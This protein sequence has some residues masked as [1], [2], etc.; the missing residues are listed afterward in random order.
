MHP[1]LCACTYWLL[2]RWGQWQGRLILT[3]HLVLCQFTNSSA[4]RTNK[5]VASKI[6][7]LL[8]QCSLST[9]TPPKQILLFCCLYEVS[10]LNA[11]FHCICKCCTPNLF[12]TMLHSILYL[13][14]VTG[15]VLF[16]TGHPIL[17]IFCLTIEKCQF[18][19]STSE[20]FELVTVF[21]LLDV[22]LSLYIYLHLDII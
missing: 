12:Q 2:I 21:V 19:M 4:D 5:P 9:T 10:S 7:G 22:S 6:K 17:L 11:S 1:G 18:W 8:L 15:K 13:T 16:R 3:E 14:F 20:V